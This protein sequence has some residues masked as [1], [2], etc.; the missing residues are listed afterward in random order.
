MWLF[1][2]IVTVVFFATFA[3][4][5]DKGLWSNTLTVFNVLL[6]G[7]IAF[8]GYAP[9]AKLVADN[10]G[11]EYTFLL[12]FLFIWTLYV[13]AFI[14]LHRVGSAMLSKTRMRFKHPIDS[15]GGPVMA[16]LAGWLMAGIVGA[17]LHTAPFD[18][19][20]FGGVFTKGRSALMNPDIAWLNIMNQ[21]MSADNLGVS[22]QEFDMQAY[23]SDFSKQ[24]EALGKQ[25]GLT[26]NR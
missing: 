17:S 14:L 10:G 18:R 19:E 15:I 26:V 24:R 9:M 2:V 25:E 1:Y 20:A 6:S 4:C 8:G 11:G 13:L 3:M 7:L 22:G 23:I 5:I 21:M 12:D 16:A